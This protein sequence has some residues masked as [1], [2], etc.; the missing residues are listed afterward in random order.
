LDSLVRIVTYQR[1][2]RQNARKSF[3]RR[4]CALAFAVREQAAMIFTRGRGR[5]LHGASLTQILIFWN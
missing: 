4:F 1:V 2:K 5:I 3:S